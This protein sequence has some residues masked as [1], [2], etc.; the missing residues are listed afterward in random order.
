MSEPTT[1]PDLG[2]PP[3]R[4]RSRAMERVFRSTTLVVGICLIG[5]ILGLIAVL[6][7][8]SARVWSRFGLGFI[9]GQMWR[10]VTGREAFGAL[11][12]IYGTLVTSAIA[13]VIAV[14][15]SVGLALLMNEVRSGWIRNPLASFVDVLAAIPSIVYGLWGLFVLRPFLDRDVEPFLRSTVGRVPVI[16]SLFHGNPNGPDMFTAGVILS[17]MVLPIIT[18]LSREVIATIPR[19]LREA[20]K[21]IG[22]TRYET[23]R[24]AVLP[25]ARSGIVGASMIG[26]GRALGET[27][28]VSMVVGNTP[29]IHGSLLGAGAT[30]PSWI[31]S[32]F[33]E[34][35]STGLHRSALL[36]LALVL[37]ALTFALAA[38]SRLL[39]GRTA[40]TVGVR[41]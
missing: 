32:S 36:G 7:S 13:I 22:A 19:D 34:A 1:P 23:I 12:L 33:R 9:T 35:T 41:L 40:R 26:L 5:L 38:I 28:A 2:A 21:A 3:F 29:I 27:I 6:V 37:V 4:R 25:S 15:V 31:A 17:I 16:G 30:I 24:L 11:P 14:P 8:G 10:P 18:A 39:V 20:A